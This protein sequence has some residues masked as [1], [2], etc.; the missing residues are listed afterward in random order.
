LLPVYHRDDPG[1]LLRSFR[2]ATVDQELVPDEVV[3]VQDGPVGESLRRVIATIVADQTTPVRHV[4][5]ADN[6]GL[7]RA[8]EQGLDACA[9]EIVARTDADDVCAPQRFSR[10]IPLVA[11]GF[12]IVGSAIRE[13]VTEG[14]EGIVRTP[15]LTP[16][17]IAAGARFHSPFNHPSV[18]YRRS[19]VRAAGGYEELP[20]LEDYWL[21]ARMLASGARACNL[22]DPLLFYR[23]GA[24]AYARR[25]GTRLLRSEFELQRRMRRIGFTSRAQ[26]ARNV[27]VR[28]GYR[29]VPEVVRRGLYRRLLADRGGMRG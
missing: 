7:A 25:G 21:F 4:V 9:Y 1:F 16:G 8:L 5:L 15:P 13:F 17:Q 26:M 14:D 12:D 3:L 11:G 10:Q 29:L 6:G 28:C 24:G 19:A 18:V 27:V 20:L 2:S 22:A 23:I